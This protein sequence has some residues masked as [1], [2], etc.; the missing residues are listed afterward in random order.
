MRVPLLLVC[1]LGMAA[2]QRAAVNEQGVEV[3]V[4][5]RAA[6]V[7]PPPA[8]VVSVTPAPDAA[9]SDTGRVMA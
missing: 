2:C 4:A 5:S 3:V 9:P 7:A 1:C 6:R 8:P